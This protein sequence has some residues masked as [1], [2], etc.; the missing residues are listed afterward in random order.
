MSEYAEIK[1]LV[2]EKSDAAV[3]LAKQIWDFAELSY[4]ETRS[5]GAM[6]EA[7]RKE[8]FTV[9]TGIA[10]IPTAFKASYSRGSGKPVMG[11]LAEYDALDGLSQKAACTEQCPIVPGAAGHGC[12]H[13]LLGSGS[14]LAAVAVKDYLDANQKDGT[15]VLFGCPAEEGAGSKQFIARAG[16]F[17]DVDFVYTWHP[18]YVNAVQSRGSVAIMG[19]NFIFDG[20]ASHAGGAPH[21]GRSALDACELMNVGV[22]Y[23]R[24]HMIDAARIHYAYSDAGGT[25]PNV[26][27]AHAVIKYEVRAPKVKQMKELFTRVTDIAKGAALM[28]GTKM[29]YEI[30]MAFSDY[31]PNKT[32]AVVM[33]ECLKECGAPNWT[34]ADY[35]LASGMLRSYP[36]A[37]QLTINEDIAAIFG[38]DDVE[39]IMRRPL[40]TT[41]HPF[42]PKDDRYESGSTD[43]GDVGY[44]TPTVQLNVATACLGNV[45]HTWQN[46]AFSCSDIG[47]K[48]MI[49]AA[50]VMALS[51]VRTMDRPD[52]IKKAREELLKKN[53]GAYR[54]P[55][56][57]YI[58]PP[59][60]SY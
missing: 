3:T 5:C 52:L 6:T 18:A 9:E 12:G 4:N 10:D 15:V 49:K 50:E 32:L 46:T 37:T 30:A 48:G 13:N 22:N 31:V 59:I 60:E 23:L 14:W 24:E 27:P 7:L 39:K 47:F 2:A 42:D 33:D 44:A 40:D 36:K 35:E 41:V 58:Q 56:P 54:C 26:V 57:D 53:G 45:G 25:A 29:R 43:V 28:T 20:I 21:L 51:T 1:K 16:Y 17:D 8:G 38:D 11:F 19:A 55:L 34:E